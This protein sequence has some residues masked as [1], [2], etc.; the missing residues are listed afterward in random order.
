MTHDG[1][2]YPMMLMCI[3]GKWTDAVAQQQQHDEEAPDKADGIR[4]EH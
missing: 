3:K 2:G 4:I 1:K